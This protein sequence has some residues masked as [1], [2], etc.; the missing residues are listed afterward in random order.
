ML[1]LI[2]I[3]GVCVWAWTK[4]KKT[5]T[6]YPKFFSRNTWVKWNLI[7]Q[8]GMAIYIAASGAF[9]LQKG[10]EFLMHD[11]VGD[12]VGMLG[13]SD[14]STLYELGEESFESERMS[15]M[16]E[17]TS[18]LMMAAMISGV[19]AFFVLI[20][21]LYTVINLKQKKY[22]EGRYMTLS[23]I[24]AIAILISIYF[25]EYKGSQFQYDVFGNGSDS[26][27][28]STRAI[29]YSLGAAVIL[30]FFLLRYK[31][32]LVAIFEESDMEVEQLQENIVAESSASNVPS[33]P[34][35]EATKQCPYCGE[36]ILAVAIKCKHCGEWM[37]EEKE[38]EVTETPIIIQC[39]ICGEDIEAGTEI[40]PHCNEQIL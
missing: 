38:E 36:T 16:T 15:M 14:L 32:N 29:L 12:I 30:G 18:P 40:C 20:I 25:V 11:W 4:Y 33:Q 24:S 13:F 6:V 39:P 9:I 3:I 1:T 27:M 26:S 2:L 35:Q 17:Y 19:S 10:T 5:P 21:T 37:P 31:K 7:V 34:Q 22:E 28:V 23:I 8:V